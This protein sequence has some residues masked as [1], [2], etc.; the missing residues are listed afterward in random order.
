M[1]WS[2]VLWQQKFRTIFPRQFKADF[3][4]AK[5]SMYTRSLLS[6]RISICS[7]KTY[8]DQISHQDGVWIF[9]AYCSSWFMTSAVATKIP[10]HLSPPFSG[11]FLSSKVFDV[12]EINAV[13]SNVDILRT[14]IYWSKE[15]SGCVN[16]RCLWTDHQ[17]C[18]NKKSKQSVLSNLRPTSL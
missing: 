18:S 2:S 16:F 3:Y 6:C 7:K 17:W 4:L 11:R 12:H 9:G 15:A 10:N 14:N 8:I 5:Y 1:D 13:M